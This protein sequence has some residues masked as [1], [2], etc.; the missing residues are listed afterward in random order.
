MDQQHDSLRKTL[1][2]NTWALQD[3]RGKLK[4]SPSSRFTTTSSVSPMSSPTP[5]PPPDFVLSISTT[6][7]NERK[8]EVT[9]STTSKPAMPSSAPSV[10]TTT[11]DPPRDSS[12]ALQFCTTEQVTDHDITGSD[13]VF[14]KPATPTTTMASSTTSSTST[15][16]HEVAPTISI[17][18]TEHLWEMHAKCSMSCRDPNAEAIDGSSAT[19]L[20]ALGADINDPLWSTACLITRPHLVKEVH[21]QSKSGR[22]SIGAGCK[23]LQVPVLT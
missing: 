22:T 12:L 20:E 5:A 9:S 19:Q 18:I 6:N 15:L 7:S 10:A 1:E 2:A 16:P 4:I 17:G 3:L 21:M 13:S 14:G 8:H 11:T 23:S